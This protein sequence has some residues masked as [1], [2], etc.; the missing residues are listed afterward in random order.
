MNFICA[1]LAPEMLRGLQSAALRRHSSR[2][3]KRNLCSRKLTS[4]NLHARARTCTR[5]TFNRFSGCGGESE[6]ERENDWNIKNVN[7]KKI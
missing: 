7:Q 5:Y 2:G 1:L 6:K 4:S 3:V